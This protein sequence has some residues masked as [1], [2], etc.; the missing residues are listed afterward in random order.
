MTLTQILPLTL[1]FLLACGPAAATGAMFAP[2]AW[3]RALAKPRWTP[4]NWVFPVTWTALYLAM[5][6]AAARVAGQ[7]GHEP[8]VGLALAFWAVQI[9]LNTLWTPVFFGLRRM[10]AGLIVIGCLWAAV[11]VTLVV[12]ARIDPVAG[13]LFLPYLV[14]VSV[15]AALNAAVLRLNPDSLPLA[16]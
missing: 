4:P 16:P 5:S 7:A 2:G 3:Y 14:W 1:V 12:F 10:R 11:A 6:L 9:G 15:A 8:G 13:L